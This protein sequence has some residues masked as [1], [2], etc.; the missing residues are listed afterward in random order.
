MT[1]P[2]NQ[3][4]A[5]LGLVAALAFFSGLAGLG[6]GAGATR[7][8]ERELTFW[9]VPRDSTEQ[10]ACRE[11]AIEVVRFPAADGIQLEGWW[12]P[13]A[14]ATSTVVLYFHGNAGHLGWRGDWICR[15][16]HLPA[17]VFAMDYRG[18]G[19]SEGRPDEV[20]LYADAEGAWLYLTEKRG[21]LPEDIVIYGK[22]LGG[23]PATWLASR[24]QARALVLQATFTSFPDL[25]AALAPW[26]PQR[27]F[28]HQRMDNR[29]RL[30]AVEAPVLIVHGGAD[31]VIPVAM[32]WALREVRP[33]ARLHI[34]PQAG[35]NDLLPRYGGRFLRD[36]RQFLAEV[37]SH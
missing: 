21:L 36:W 25:A 5:A 31:E 37:D 24:V 14:A 23:A 11:E 28:V 35:H 22:S 18:Y 3:G 20:G 10:P 2:A 13:P 17:A 8:F 29:S 4:A 27:I 16:R 32:A 1:V 9:P 34:Y 30:P 15:L 19:A 6:I 12:V 7:W 26:V 33:D